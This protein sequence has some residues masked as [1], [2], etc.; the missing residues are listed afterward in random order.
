M[1]HIEGKNLKVNTD[2]TF[3]CDI[4][5]KKKMSQ[6]K[7][8]SKNAKPKTKRL[9]LMYVIVEMREGFKRLE[10]RM[11]R[12]EMRMDKIENDINNI[13]TKNNLVR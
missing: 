3:S 12:L 6:V 4:I 5:K 9:T 1:K 13:V 11:D 8:I 2:R 10:T 7:P